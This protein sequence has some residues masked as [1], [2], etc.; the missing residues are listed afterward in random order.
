MESQ[1]G[2]FCV[3]T[4]YHNK[5]ESSRVGEERSQGRSTDIRGEEKGRAKQASSQLSC[6][7]H[8]T[9][10]LGGGDLADF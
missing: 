7:G 4:W 8:W 6:V 3:S 10:S 2:N 5:A 9:L 1:K